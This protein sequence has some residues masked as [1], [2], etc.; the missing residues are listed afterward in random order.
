[1]K[2]NCGYWLESSVVLSVA[3]LEKEWVG[4]RAEVRRSNILMYRNTSHIMGNPKTQ[5][6]SAD[7]HYAVRTGSTDYPNGLLYGQSPK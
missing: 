4:K 5:P 7:P 1:M 6:R 3:G 2:I